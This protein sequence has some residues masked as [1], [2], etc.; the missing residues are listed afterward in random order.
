MEK[1]TQTPETDNHEK[2]TEQNETIATVKAHFQKQ[3]DE[4]KKKHEEEINKLN[5]QLEEEKARHIQN[6]KDILS[7]GKVSIP[8]EETHAPSEE[9]EI[10]K[11]MRA[12]YHLN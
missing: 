3:L 6:I 11:T 7:S 2:P 4:E 9:E 5:K 8:N 1:Q 10:L 12:K